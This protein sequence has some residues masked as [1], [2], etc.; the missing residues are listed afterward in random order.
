[1]KNFLIGIGIAATAWA[2]AGYV[3]YHFAFSRCK[4]AQPENKTIGTDW[5]THDIERI[6][7]SATDGTPLAALAF[8]QPEPTGRWVIAA[9]GYTSYKEAMVYAA[10]ELCARGFNVLLPD[11]RGHGETGGKAI[12][13]G[14]PDR[15]DIVTWSN[16]LCKRDPSCQI[17]LYGE[18]MGAATVMMASGEALPAQVTH[19]VADCG[20]T[21]VLNILKHRIRTKYHLPHWLFLPPGAVFTRIFAGYNLYTASALEQVRYNTRSLL[22]IHGDADVEVPTKMVYDLQKA[23]GGRVKHVIA[24]GFAHGEA[25]SMDGYWDIVADWF[26]N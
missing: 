17:L 19:I 15:L 2:A 9:H 12:G 22:L 25:H 21:S 6:H 14:W 1:M 11:L 5:W 18:S 23:A 20:Y 16:W 24:E 8:V 4:S 7:I 10:R 3:F 26:G 13:M